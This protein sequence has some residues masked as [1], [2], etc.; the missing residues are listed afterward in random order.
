MFPIR[1]ETEKWDSPD[2]VDAFML[3]LR[4]F[5]EKYGFPE[6]LECFKEE[7]EELCSQ[8]PAHVRSQF[9]CSLQEC[10]IRLCDQKEVGDE[11]VALMPLNCFLTDFLRRVIVYLATGEYT[12]NPWLSRKPDFKYVLNRDL[13]SFRVVDERTKEAKFIIRN[14]KL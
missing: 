3:V 2:S 9:A 7:F 13:I 5:N 14:I 8:V 4:E 6:K 10:L 11:W 1:V 12:P